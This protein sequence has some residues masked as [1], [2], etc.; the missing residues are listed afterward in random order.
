[1]EEL[2][3]ASLTAREEFSGSKVLK[4]LVVRNDINR[5]GRAF[6]I[7]SPGPKSFIDG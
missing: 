3:P 7:V 2:G 4:V 5:L 1:M 6:E